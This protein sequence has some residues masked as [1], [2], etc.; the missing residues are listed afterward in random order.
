MIHESVANNDASLGPQQRNRGLVSM[1]ELVFF[2]SWID[3]GRLLNGRI[4]ASVC[5][6][7]GNGQIMSS[8]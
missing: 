2:D 7:A 1:G 8:Q 3:V 5:C 6:Y 4:L